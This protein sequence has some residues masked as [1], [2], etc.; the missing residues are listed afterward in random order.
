MSTF[1]APKIG[2]AA[3]SG[4]AT[5]SPTA[6]FD[7]I[8]FEPDGTSGAADPTDEFDG[9]GLDECRW[10]AIV[11]E[12]PTNYEV[13]D[14]G[15]TI[16]TTEGDI[17][18]TPNAAGATNLCCSRTPTCRR[19]TRETQAVGDVHRRLRPGGPARLRR[20]RQ[21]R[22]AR[23]HLRHRAGPHQPGR[24]ALRVELGHPGPA[25]PGR[26]AGQRDVVPPAAD[27]GRGRPTSVRSP[28]TAAEWQPVGTVDT[29]RPT[30]T[31]A[32]SPS[33]CSSRAGPRR[34]TTSGSPRP[35]PRTVRPSPTTT[36]PPLGGPRGRHRR[37]GRRHR[38]RR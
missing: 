28:S 17:Y 20:R 25:A 37:A 19:T 9:N 5:T 2:P 13:A 3:V 4:G 6:T 38:P 12:D 16:T 8:R 15:L 30:W 35:Q 27:Q 22:Q 34:S 21:L 24:A 11:R 1:T 26:P 33:A 7:W 18:Q 32:C 29:R 36:P 31:S 10:N 23:R 14:G